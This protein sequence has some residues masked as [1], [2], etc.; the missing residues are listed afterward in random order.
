[1]SDNKYLYSATLILGNRV[2]EG[3][4]FLKINTPF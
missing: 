1:M 4:A 2:L 3:C